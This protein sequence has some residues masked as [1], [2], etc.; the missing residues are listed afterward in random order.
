MVDLQALNVTLWGP[1]AAGKTMLLAQLCGRSDESASPW[2]VRPTEEARP[3]LNLARDLIMLRNE[4]PRATGEHASQLR[5]HFFNKKTNAEIELS[6][7]D[8]KGQEFEKLNDETR[9]R[10]TEAHGIVLLFDPATGGADLEK[11]IMESVEQ[12]RM[13]RRSSGTREPRDPRP[14][15]ICIS[16]ADLWVRTAKDVERAKNEPDDFVRRLL[17]E[18]GLSRVLRHIEDYC[19]NYRLYPIS[20]V[21]VHLQRGSVERAVF[22]D[23]SGAPRLRAGAN[24]INLIE[25][26]EWIFSQLTKNKEAGK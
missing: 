15:A 20:A 24:P 21:G 1:S 19:E 26:F 3:F 4:F 2:S 11:Q 16:K 8:R 12:V 17:R 7:E 23:E 13:D 10:L 22:L 9:K 5:L 25:P 18:K 6:I 14:Y